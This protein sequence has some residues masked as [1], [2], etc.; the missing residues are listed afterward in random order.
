MNKFIFVIDGMKLLDLSNLG[1]DFFILITQIAIAF[2]AGYVV[3]KGRKIYKEQ[4]EEDRK[5]Y[6]RQKKVDRKEYLRELKVNTL[7]DFIGYKYDLKGD[8]FLKALNEVFIVFHDSDSVIRKWNDF[9]NILNKN[10]DSYEHREDVSNKKLY[11]LFKEMCEDLGMD[12]EKYS[13]ESFTKIF[14]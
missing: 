10:F 3:I 8:G 1:I 13:Y 9:H 4:K 7:K 5:L 11:L 2:F 12:A 14:N 6:E